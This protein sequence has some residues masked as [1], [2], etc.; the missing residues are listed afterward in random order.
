VEAVDRGEFLARAGKL[1]LAAGAGGVLSACSS[2]SKGGSATTIA[3][4]AVTTTIRRGTLG[5][6]TSAELRELERELRGPV[7]TPGE[8]GYAQARLEYDTVFDGIKPRAVAYCE[9]LEDV[10]RAVRWAGK[11]GVRIVARCGG[12]SYGGY[13]TVGPG[14]VVDVSRL[15]RISVGGSVATVGAGLAL[16]DLYAGLW[17][18][19]VTVPGGSCPTVGI[20]G[21]ALGGGVGLSGRKFGTTADNIRQVTIV[22]AGGRAL[23][24][25]EQQNS[26]LYWACR[27]GGGGNFGI[28]TSFVFDTHPVDEVTTFYVQ[29]PWEDAA[30]VVREWQDLVPHAPDGLMGLCN[31]SATGDPGASPVVSA[32]GQFYGGEAELRSV[33]RPLLDVGS[34]S[35][36]FVRRTYLEAALYWAGCSNDTVAECHVQGA[37]PHGVLPRSTF[38]AKSRYALRPLS[39]PGIRAL[40]A[41]IE[42]R[43]RNRRLGGGGII[44]D[45]YGGAI[46]RVAADATAF[47]HRNAIFS[48]QFFASW[49]AGAPRSVVNAN[50]R[51]ID[52]YYSSM[53][54]H[55]SRYAYQNYI[56]P[57]LADWQQAYY[58]SNLARLISV[59]RKYDPANF[60]RF[61][62]SIPTHG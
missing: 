60:F 4:R 59:K 12:H 11:N 21:L 38:K 30:R 44:L 8:R 5:P 37:S 45:S 23:V 24:C 36:S 55:V 39:A 50:L 58:G 29:W 20:S 61:R 26:D 40:L 43:Q 28:V 32:A 10:Q 7:L 51:W 25:N 14:V 46:N 13:S 22:T 47:V 35:P 2:G 48:M 27:G 3:S 52:A 33:L 6:P 41:G 17:R 42:S 16:I 57:D 19:R 53:L 31:L 15:R 49:S 18:H 34:P 54:P 9:G 1:A 62:Q 56:D